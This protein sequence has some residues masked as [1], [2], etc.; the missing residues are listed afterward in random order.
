MS[1]PT[2]LL[3]F[4]ISIRTSLVMNIAQIKLEFIIRCRCTRRSARRRVRSGDETDSR[5]TPNNRIPFAES[6]D[7]LQVP[8]KRRFILAT[9]RATCHPGTLQKK[10]KSDYYSLQYATYFSGTQPAPTNDE[11]RQG[12]AI[13]QLRGM[14]IMRGYSR[15]ASHIIGCARCCSLS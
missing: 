11:R 15:N 1:N 9:S 13:S 4:S 3:F 8:P 7:T 2:S 14:F 6:K 10:S 5:F 12:G